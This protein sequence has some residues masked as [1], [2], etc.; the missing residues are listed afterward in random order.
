M[1]LL[2]PI[3][4]LLVSGVSELEFAL[5]SRQFSPLM[6]RVDERRGLVAPMQAGDEVWGALLHMLIMFGIC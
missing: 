2:Q 4:G 3:M 1:G 5:G 6:G